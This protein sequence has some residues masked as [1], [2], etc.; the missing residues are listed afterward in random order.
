MKHFFK[1]FCVMSMMGAH[2][3]E[4]PPIQINSIEMTWNMRLFFFECFRDPKFFEQ[5]MTPLAYVTKEHPYLLDEVRATLPLQFLNRTNEMLQHGAIV[6]NKFLSQT[7]PT[8]MSSGFG[9]RL[10]PSAATMCHRA[11]LP[12]ARLQLMQLLSLIAKKK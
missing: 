4:A 7:S 8:N 11:T 10:Y 2:E 12:D 1:I 5:G 3:L 9:A 6:K